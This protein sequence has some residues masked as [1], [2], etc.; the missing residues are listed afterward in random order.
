[1][2]NAGLFEG[3]KIELLNGWIVEM[4]PEGPDHA[5]L[6]TAANECFI[7]FSQGRYWVANLRAGELIVYRDPVHGNYQSEQQFTTGS[8]SPLALPGVTINVQTL[9]P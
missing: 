2:I 8:I 5:D 6:S 7:R 3:R 4:P 1:M 9:L